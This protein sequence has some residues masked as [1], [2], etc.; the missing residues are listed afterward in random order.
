MANYFEDRVTVEM[1]LTF[2]HLMTINREDTFNLDNRI[3]LYSYY[4]VKNLDSI[5]YCEQEDVDFSYVSHVLRDVFNVKDNGIEN[6]GN[7]KRVETWAKNWK[8][9]SLE[10]IYKYH[11]NFDINNYYINNTNNDINQ[12]VILSFFTPTAVNIQR[13][14]FWKFGY[15]TTGHY[16]GLRFVPEQELISNKLAR[17]SEDEIHNIFSNHQLYVYLCLYISFLSRYLYID[18]LNIFFSNAGEHIY[19]LLD[20]IIDYY[21][22]ANPTSYENTG[23][24]DQ[25]F[26]LL[27]KAL[28]DV[29]H[30]YPNLKN[31]EFYTK[32]KSNIVEKWIKISS[33]RTHIYVPK[34]DL[35]HPVILDN[36]I[37]Y[38]IIDD[39]EYNRLKKRLDNAKKYKKFIEYLEYIATIDNVTNYEKRE[40]HEIGLNSNNRSK[41]YILKVTNQLME[42]ISDGTEL[43]SKL[44]E[45]INKYRFPLSKLYLSNIILL[46][47]ECAKD[48]NI[49][50]D[51]KISGS[52]LIKYLCQYYRNGATHRLSRELVFNNYLDLYNDLLSTSYFEVPVLFHAVHDRAFNLKPAHFFHYEDGKLPTEILKESYDVLNECKEK[53]IIDMI[54]E[55]QDELIELHNEKYRE[56]KKELIFEYIINQNGFYL[57]NHFSIDLIKQDIVSFDVTHDRFKKTGSDTILN[58]TNRFVNFDNYQKYPCVT[59]QWFEIPKIP[60]TI[61]LY[62]EYRSRE[63]GKVIREYLNE[64]VEYFKDRWVA[65]HK[66]FS[67]LVN[68]YPNMEMYRHH[69]FDWLGQQHVDIY[70]PKYRIAI[71]RQGIQH[72]ES[73]DFFGGEE[74]LKMTKNRD[75]RKRRLCKENNVVLLE[76]KYDDDFETLITKIHTIMDK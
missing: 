73:V 34:N 55:Y 4:V 32:L 66:L 6:Y 65:E 52:N 54:D 42:H 39:N 24:Y 35:Y 15:Y 64:N 49:Y 63:V 16:E 74:G 33:D 31:S 2:N 38:S 67:D 23:V 21:K 48:D 30:I 68:R 46:D 72:Y 62:I 7:I 50:I 56:S 28:N 70:I 20:E 14:V 71:E 61:D 27:Y 10:Y 11:F 26:I 8:Q 12:K 5:L 41:E 69:T 37:K 43:D 40:K 57:M 59:Q 19:S 75:A 36:A 22:R 3:N 44:N 13:Y 45:S 47:H 51:T 76:H 1:I 17:I 53:K 18:E 58:L 60:E 9:N 29:T 25:L